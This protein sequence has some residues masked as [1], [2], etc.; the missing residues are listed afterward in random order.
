MISS[1]F[2]SVLMINRG[3]N[4]KG[5]LD[6]QIQGFLESNSCNSIV[7]RR[8][9]TT[10]HW[11]NLKR[12]PGKVG[13]STDYYCQARKGSNCNFLFVPQKTDNI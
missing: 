11:H 6:L 3:L 5:N 1:K 7:L 2:L 10:L 13:V 8:D 4:V 12:P 9:D